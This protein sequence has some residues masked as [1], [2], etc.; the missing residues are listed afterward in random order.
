[1]HINVTDPIIIEMLQRISIMLNEESVNHVANAI[2][3]EECIRILQEAQD[4][5]ID[6][7]SIAIGRQPEPQPVPEPIVIPEPQSIS[8]QLRKQASLRTFQNNLGPSIHDTATMSNGPS[9]PGVTENVNFTMP[10]EI[11]R[12]KKI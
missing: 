2:L 5:G 6:I 1:M 12:V 7:D 9:V 11:R 3:Q 10:G 8:E 4:D